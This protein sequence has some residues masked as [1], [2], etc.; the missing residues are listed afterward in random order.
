MPRGNA[1]GGEFDMGLP[2]VPQPPLAPQAPLPSPFPPPNQDFQPAQPPPPPPQVSQQPPK[3]ESRGAYPKVPQAFVPTAAP[4]APAAPVFVPPPTGVAAAAAANLSTE[5]V[6]KAQKYCKYANSALTY[7]D[8]NTAILN[9]HKAL[10]L[11]T[12]GVDPQ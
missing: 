3:D 12:T 2:Q 8:I 1:A 11:L 10:A 5:Q 6:L 4:A 7:E 9:L